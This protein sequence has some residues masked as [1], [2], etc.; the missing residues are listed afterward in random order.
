MP[1][2]RS[3]RKP[4]AFVK[5]LPTIFIIFFYSLIIAAS[6]RKKLTIVEKVKI[7]QEVEKN[8]I[9]LT[10]PTLGEAVQAL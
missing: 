8:P 2:L 10:V 6:K 4:G 3:L 5:I 9:T 1:V 7:I